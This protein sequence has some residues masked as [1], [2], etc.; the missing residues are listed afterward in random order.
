MFMFSATDDSALLQ[1]VRIVVVLFLCFG[2]PFLIG[3]AVARAL[4]LRDLANK[5]SWILCALAIASSPFA[6]QLYMKKPLSDAIPL[7]IDLAGGSNLVYA[8]DREQQGDENIDNALME[9]MVRAIRRRINPDG[10]KDVVVRQVGVDRVEVI[11]PGADKQTVDDFK[12]KITNLGSLEFAILATPRKHQSIIEKALASK[13]DNVFTAGKLVAKWR[14]IMPVV[15]DGVAQPN[16]EF[17]GDTNIVTRPNEEKIQETGDDGYKELLVVVDPDPDRR[18]TGRY[19]RRAGVTNDEQGGLAVEFLFN[20]EGARRFRRLTRENKPL[21]DDFHFRLAILLDEQIK[22]APSINQEIG[23]RGIIQGRFTSKEVND[24]VDVL[25]AGALPVPLMK[26]P[27]QEFTV[28]AL[29]G[30][31]TVQKGKFAITVASLAVVFFM[32][33]YYGRHA[34]VIADLGLLINI[35][36]VVGVMAFIKAAFTLP[37]LAGLVLTI[38]MAV[39]AN[40]LIFERIREELG[41]GSSLRMAIHNGFARA[42][43]TIVDANV[44]TL[45]TAVILYFI[46]TDQVKGFAVTLFIGIV[47]SMFTSLYVGR[48]FFDILERKRWMTELK[49][50]SLI[51]AT[52]WDFVSKQSIAAVASVVLIVAGMFAFFSRGEDN[53]DIDF[54]G[55]TMLNF[56]FADPSAH[57]DVEPVREKL[58]ATFSKQFNSD[59]TLE[60]LKDTEGVVTGYRLRTTITQEDDKADDAKD[61][62]ETA[63]SETFPDELSRITM[64]Y[65]TVESIVAV[66]EDSDAKTAETKKDE[67]AKEVDDALNGHSVVLAF[68]SEMSFD[69][70]IRKL[71]EQLI[72]VTGE[73]SQPKYSDTDSMFSY[74]GIEGTGVEASSN[75]IQ[76]FTKIQ[77]IVDPALAKA[78]LEMALAKTQTD[79]A[80]NPIFTGVQRFEAQVASEAKL[81]ALYAMFTSLAAIVAYIWLR[82]QRITFGFAAVAALVHDVLC[83]MGAVALASYASG[84]PIGPILLLDDFKINLPMIAAFL[85]IVGYSLN[86]TIVVFDRIREV[87]GKNPD[88]DAP[89]V[90]K[91]LNQTLS[92][93]LLTS[94]TTLIVVAILYAFGG[95]G[96]H[97]FAFCLVV[98]VFV[99]TYSSIYVA[100][101]VLLWLMNVAK[102]REAT[103]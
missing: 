64:E 1:F 63:V 91:S 99:G 101:P 93:T 73:D 70:V 38:G 94:L 84:T 62:V 32:L 17:D 16:T 55:G 35:V 41:R 45:L 102:K 44:T 83:V 6:Y 58:R 46:G 13:S 68:S 98:G 65:E 21:Q 100:S 66:E 19:L 23:A 20:N 54:R 74:E 42:F 89:M 56:S 67:P 24:L 85:T 90:N 18:V 40:V 75:E 47:M 3:N 61:L 11:I 30:E 69:T 92:R 31:T 95:E 51:G 103:A 49:M 5:I 52:S 8:L 78:D 53:Y 2:A 97:G 36:L 82:F 37:G 25:N 15:E 60:P 80:A 76:K 71:G 26:N 9:R 96:I 59:I 50:R 29:L 77:L 88:L 79:M 7:G 57:Q 27:I 87:R 48:L 22:S 43:T 81:F 86:D 33:I 28:G 14:P 10:T 72:T 34:G 4:K 39:D 12:K